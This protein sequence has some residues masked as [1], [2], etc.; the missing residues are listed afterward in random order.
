METVGAELVNAIESGVKYRS[1]LKLIVQ[2]FAS[3]GQRATVFDG[4]LDVLVGGQVTRYIAAVI[5][6]GHLFFVLGNVMVLW[7]HRYSQ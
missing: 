3:F 6:V 2:T 5:A 4:I 1:Y 7:C